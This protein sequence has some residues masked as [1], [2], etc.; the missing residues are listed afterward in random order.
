M[1]KVL[2]ITILISFLSINSAYSGKGY[3]GKDY[4]KNN[5]T[6]S[7]KEI[8]S[9]D[10]KSNEE[11]LKKTNITVK[12]RIS[13]KEEI[14]IRKYI[15]K[16][17]IDRFKIF[18]GNVKIINI[19]LNKKSFTLTGRLISPENKP[20]DLVGKFCEALQNCKKFDFVIPSIIKKENI[21]EQNKVYFVLT[22]DGNAKKI[23]N[24][25]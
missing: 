11:T 16:N 1:K 24:E 25:Q 20:M 15:T 8:T 21:E 13:S 14:K 18:K 6:V 7:N 3:S 2:I 4:I 10:K 9:L 22:I 23:N 19:I 5:E 17:I 12:P